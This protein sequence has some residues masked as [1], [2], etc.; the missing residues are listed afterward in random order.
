MNKKNTESI[1]EEDNARSKFIYDFLQKEKISP[2]NNVPIPKVIM[3]YWHS[4][5]E[6][7]KDVLECIDSWKVLIN[8][9]FR[10][11]F[12]DDESAKCFIKKHLKKEHIDSYLKCHHPAMRCDY[13]RLCYLYVS[14]GLYVDSDELLL[15]IEIDF[16]FENNNIKIQPLCYSLKEEKMIDN[17]D[18]LRCPYDETNVYYFNNNPIISPPNHHLIALALKRATD[19]LV[20]DDNIFDIQATTEPGNLSASLVNYHIN[21]GNDVEYIDGTIDDSTKIY[22]MAGAEEQNPN[23]STEE[24]CKLIE[25]IGRH[26]IERGTLYNIINDYKGF[27]WSAEK[28]SV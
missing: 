23:L 18:F 15:N 7:P 8:K 28:A 13:F 22:S 14:G 3:Q 11:D 12:F 19:K 27:D 26:P 6:I 2:A 21:G 25:D 1:A 9:G 5:K 4:S 24:L 17:R 16:L 10:F 20:G